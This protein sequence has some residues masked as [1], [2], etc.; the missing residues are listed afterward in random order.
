VAGFSVRYY[1]MIVGSNVG[2][3]VVL[4][5]WFGLLSDR[6]YRGL[7]LIGSAL[8]AIY[9]LLLLGRGAHSLDRR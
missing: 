8:L 3:A 5:R 2:L 6:A 9:G 1:S 4:H 7:L